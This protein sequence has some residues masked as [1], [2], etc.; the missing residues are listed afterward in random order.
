MPNVFFRLS[1]SVHPPTADRPLCFFF[2]FFFFYFIP[3]SFAR[4]SVG[5]VPN[6]FVCNRTQSSS[7][8]IALCRR[9]KMGF[10]KNFS[11]LTS[12]FIWRIP[13]IIEDAM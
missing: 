3:S 11:M 5:H 13:R 8:W 12:C 2:F 10:L 1:P 9:E 4:G 6:V 7:A